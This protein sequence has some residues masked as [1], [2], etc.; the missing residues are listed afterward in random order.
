MRD[1]APG[2]KRARGERRLWRVV[3]APP[4]RDPLGGRSDGLRRLGYLLALVLTLGAVVAPTSSADLGL[5]GTLFTPTT[6]DASTPSVLY[7]LQ[8]HSAGSEELFSVLMTPPPFATAGGQA[9]GQSI[10]GPTAIA[11][12]GPGT[13]GDLVQAPSVITPC[14]SRESAFHGY[15]TGPASVDILLPPNS[16][17]TLAVRYD[18][19]RRAPWVDSDFKLAFTTQDHT[20]GT[21]PAG[22]PFAAPPTLTSAVTM[23]T[24]GPLVG[25]RTGAHILLRTSPQGT[26]GTPAAPRPISR[27]QAVALSGRLLPALG[28]HRIVLQ[29]ARGGGRLQTLTTVRTDARGHFTAPPW[30]P[31]APGTYELWASYP[32][33]PGGL[34]ADTTSCPQRFT[35]R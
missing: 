23:T 13:L 29:W 22:S 27:H 6:V 14:S 16:A 31:G 4:P 2:A 26:P 19:G 34:V 32:A 25:D 18:T 24:A 33:Q 35:V 5:A 9:E 3:G 11:L 10:D 1:P 12:Q 15:A 17:T 30:R 8:M 20:V 7:Y 21:Y 28:G